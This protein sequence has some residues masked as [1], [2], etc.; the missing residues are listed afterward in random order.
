MA[1]S[2]SSLVLPDQAGKRNS[3]H[4]LVFEDLLQKESNSDQSLLDHYH[5][6]RL[7]GVEIY[8]IEFDINK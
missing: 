2:G 8:S 4:G 5:K 3:R 1:S 7:K 6:T